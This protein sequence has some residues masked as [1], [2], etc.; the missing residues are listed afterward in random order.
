MFLVFQSIYHSLDVVTSTPK[1]G[2]LSASP[3][4]TDS[5]T[6]PDIGISYEE[7]NEEIVETKFG[8]PLNTE[9][10][11]LKPKLQDPEFTP[12]MTPAEL[13]RAG[14]HMETP[15]F[16][17]NNTAENFSASDIDNNNQL[18]PVLNLD[19][20]IDNEVQGTGVIK[21][22]KSPSF[23]PSPVTGNH[24]KS[25]CLADFTSLKKITHKLTLVSNS[26]F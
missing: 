8:S 20:N 12:I 24:C 6:S 9:P 7:R 17:D 3:Q 26:F 14:M 25:E 5:E 23:V 19:E 16:L 2:E 13:G 18:I 15:S 4:G 11:K 22:E 21:D 10:L 1:Q